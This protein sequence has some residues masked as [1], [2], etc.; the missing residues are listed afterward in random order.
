[1]VG[2]ECVQEYNRTINSSTKFEP[3]YLLFGKQSI[4]CPV[5]SMNKCDISKDRE[6]AFLNSTKSFESNKKRFD[7]TRK[8]YEFKA[9]DKAY[10]KNGSKLN[11][12]KMDKIRLG[13]YPII[14]QISSSF[15]EV[16]CGKKKKVSNYFHSSKL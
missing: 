15:Y 7:K 10:V 8:E 9:E 3:A 13:P 4:I 11:R 16:G 1:M 6:E 5:D 14:K 12:N 2:E